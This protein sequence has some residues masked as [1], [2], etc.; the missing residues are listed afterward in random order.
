[1]KKVLMVA[2]LPLM[3]GQFNIPNINILQKMGYKVDIAANFENANVWPKEKIKKFIEEMKSI[4]VECFH[5]NFSRNIFNIKNH[6]YSLKQLNQLIIDNDYSFIH[7]HTPIASV[8][9]RI[10]AHLNKLKVIYTAHGFHFYTGS[11]LKNWLLF[12]PIE[13]LMSFW[14]DI[15]VTINTEDYKRA[16]KQFHAKTTKYIPGVG[17]DTKKFASC[18]VN[19]NEKR[20]ELKVNENQFVLLSVGELQNRKNQRIVIDALNKL[21]NP[22]I[23]YLIVGRGELENEYNNLIKFYNLEQ[24]IKLLGFR[25]DINELCKAAD[26]FIHPSVREGFGIAPM[27][28]MAAGL[29]LIASNINGLLD[30]IEDGKTGCSIAPRSVDEVANAIKKMYLNVEFRRQCGIYNVEKAKKFDIYKINKVMQEIYESVST[31]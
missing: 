15:L 7:T 28:A 6:I 10:V 22:H 11:P 8:L 23:V 26:C 16:K 1:M 20:Q 30:F 31:S 14:T 25:T 24:N 3:I 29:P 13:W 18:N 19:R 4:D 9:A 2:T 5:V 27:E 21:K 12:Y 17:V